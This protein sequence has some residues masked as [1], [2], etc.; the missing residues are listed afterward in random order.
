MSIGWKLVPLVA[1]AALLG[2]AVAAG[3]AKPK[4]DSSISL[5]TAPEGDE[6]VFR[7]RVRS[8]QPRCKRRRRVEVTAGHDF[9]ARGTI[10]EGVTRTDRR[11]RYELRVEAEQ[12]TL[13]GYRAKTPRKARKRHV[14]KGARTPVVPF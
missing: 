10:L 13:G 4:Y 1:V 7:G 2:L 11:G 12:N 3:A 9:S 8:E 6:F 5:K 14:C